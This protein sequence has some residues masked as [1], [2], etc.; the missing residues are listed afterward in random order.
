MTPY[1]GSWFNLLQCLTTVEECAMEDLAFGGAD[2][3]VPLAQLTST[4]D[5]YGVFNIQVF[6]AGDQDEEIKQTLTFSSNDAEVF[7]CTNPDAVGNEE[8]EGMYDP[9]ATIDDFSC[10]LGCTV[11]LQLTEVTPPTC[12][13]DADASFAVEATGLKAQ[14]TSTWTALEAS[15]A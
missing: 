1:G 11:D 7:G 15:K 6:P 12:H 10:V 8:G 3:R 9:N 4:G 5:V 14:T 13:G 2:N